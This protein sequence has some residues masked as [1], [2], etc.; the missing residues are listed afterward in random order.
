MDREVVEFHGL[1]AQE[2]DFI[3]VSRIVY[4][5]NTPIIGGPEVLYIRDV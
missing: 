1:N 4:G 2:K 3:P 5:W